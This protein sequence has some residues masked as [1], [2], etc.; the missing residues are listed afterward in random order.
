MSFSA[1][2]RS[3]FRVPIRNGFAR[4]Q[5]AGVDSKRWD[6]GVDF[7]FWLCTGRCVDAGVLSA[8]GWAEAAP[9]ELAVGAAV[10]EVAVDDEGDDLWAAVVGIHNVW[11][12]AFWFD[13][14]VGTDTIR[15]ANH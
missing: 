1:L 13:R 10:A 3:Q 14:S 7:Q 4:P 11:L 9:A 8:H 5:G 6:R 12:M 2:S 15:R